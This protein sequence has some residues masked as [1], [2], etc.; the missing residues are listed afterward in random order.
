MFNN[1]IGASKFMEE[2]PVDLIFLGYSDAGNHG[3]EFAHNISKRTLVIFTHGLHEYAW[4]V[5][6]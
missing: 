5:T 1:A 3:I 4:I 6:R 2:N